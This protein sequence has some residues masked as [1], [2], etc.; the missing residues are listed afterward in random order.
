MN[1]IPDIKQKIR[2]VLEGAGLSDNPEEF[3]S[4]IHSWRCEYPDTYGQCT[5]FQELLD[6]L[7][8]L[9]TEGPPCSTSS[10]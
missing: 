9:S 1:H 2:A 8:A 4:S 5:C 6:Q 7:V 3:D 10:S